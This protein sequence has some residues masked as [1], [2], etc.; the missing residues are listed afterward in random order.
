MCVGALRFFQLGT[1]ENL[2]HVKAY[3]L[4]GTLRKWDRD[5]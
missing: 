1:I 3:G 2:E 4:I 5:G